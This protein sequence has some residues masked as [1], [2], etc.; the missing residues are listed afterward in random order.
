MF[1]GGN[2]GGG[3]AT[4]PVPAYVPAFAPLSCKRAL[5]ACGSAMPPSRPTCSWVWPTRSGCERRA[6][7]QLL[8]LSTIFS[9]SAWLQRMYVL[10]LLT[11]CPWQM[12]TWAT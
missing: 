12:R 9:L 3:H 7:W 11:F 2:E 5:A 1:F 10:H 4:L 8:I 6:V